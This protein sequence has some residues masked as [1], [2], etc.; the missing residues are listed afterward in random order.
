MV[1]CFIGDCIKTQPHEASTE[2]GASHKGS[3]LEEML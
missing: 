2:E 3:A 1:F